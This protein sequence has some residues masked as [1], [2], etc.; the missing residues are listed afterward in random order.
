MKL[1]TKNIALMAAFAALF[2]IS[3]LIS[4]FIPAVGIPEITIRL[5][6]LLASVFGLVMGPYLG[7]LTAFLGALLTWVLS[8]GSSFGL[9]FLLSPPLNA[10]IVGLIFYRKWKYAFVV[11]AVLI[12]AFWF[13]PPSQP[14]TEFWYVGLAVTWDK[15]IALALIFPVV[16]LAKFGTLKMQLL[17]YFLLAF[18]GNQADNM[19]G[20]LVFAVPVVHEG[21]FGTSLETVRFLF[22]VSPFVYPIIRIIQAAIV[23]V[24]AIPLLRALQSSGLVSLK[25]SILP[26]AGVAS[27][28]E[29]PRR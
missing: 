7:F 28:H 2:Y 19:W 8:G 9:P 29:V 11:F 23:M 12:A 22:V 24:I 1:T 6:A 27:E 13:L 25:E 14:L 17:F 21:I 20:S 3:S 15:I 16:K 10:L 18:I 26:E 4:P 5:E